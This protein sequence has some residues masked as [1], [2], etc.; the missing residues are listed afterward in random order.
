M[1]D[2]IFKH[3]LDATDNGQDEEQ[4]DLEEISE[5]ET[6][7]RDESSIMTTTTV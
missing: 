4:S 3:V 2:S 1:F 7:N 5:T 6:T